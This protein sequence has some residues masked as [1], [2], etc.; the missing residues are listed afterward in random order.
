MNKRNLFFALMVGGALVSAAE[1][2]DAVVFPTAWK[3]S[4]QATVTPAAD[5]ILVVHAPVKSAGLAGPVRVIPKRRY[6]F[7]CEV[8]GSGKVQLAVSG[9]FGWAYGPATV[10][11][12]DWKTL[13]VTYANTTPSVSLAL[14]SLIDGASTFE[15]RNFTGT[16]LPPVELSDGEMPVKLFI[17][18]DHPGHNGKLRKLADAADGRAIWGKRWYCFVQL[19]V[20]ANSRPVHYYVH[21]RKNTDA[22]MELYLLNGSQKIHQPVKFTARDQW[23]W[24]KLAPVQAEI[25][26]PE[27][28]LSCA[29]DP[30]TELWVDKVVLSTDGELT[31]AALEQVK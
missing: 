31:A 20:P 10:L 16:P 18:A 2:P 6:V 27:V 25:A 29:G 22:A 1:V 17:A 23:T 7:R 9:D 26:L 8:R 24:V 28:V 5:G 30:A 14:Y 19:P 12:N 11:G 3:V 4:L 15:V 13:E 21:L